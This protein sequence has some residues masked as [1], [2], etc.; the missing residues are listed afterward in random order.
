MLFVFVQPCNSV[1]SSNSDGGKLRLADKEVI[2]NQTLELA[3]NELNVA[4]F[5]T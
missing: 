4:Y 2:G 3:E 1:K 5:H